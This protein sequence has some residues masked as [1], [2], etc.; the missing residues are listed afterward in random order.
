MNQYEKLLLVGLGVF[1]LP[2]LGLF[3]LM[4]FRV[5]RQLPPDRRMPHSLF[6]GGWN[7]VHD[8]Y[9]RFYP[10][11]SLYQLT[12]SSAFA[13]LLLALALVGFRIWGYLRGN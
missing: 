2:A 5:N 3:H 9:E 7:K 4:V 1:Y 12:V 6:W 13:F 10:R 11:S 8:E